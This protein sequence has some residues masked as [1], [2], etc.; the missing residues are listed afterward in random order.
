MNYLKNFSNL[1]N[2]KKSLL[3]CIFSTLLFQFIVTTIVFITIYKFKIFNPYTLN[4][5]ALFVFIIFSIGLIA[6]MTQPN[7]K[8]YQ[9]FILFTIFS[10]TEG[11]F[12]SF[13]L[14]LINVDTIMSALIGTIALFFVMFV[15]GLFGVYYNIDLTWMGLILFL[16]LLGLIFALIVRLFMPY[17]NKMNQG[18]V[19]FALILFS[20]YVIY[21]TNQILLR[22]DNNTN[23]DCIMGSLDYYLDLINIFVNMI[24]IFNK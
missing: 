10:I 6:L 19:I 16:L 17:S 11:V 18:L 12:L 21:D 24:S 8:F 13:C 22:Y 14:K 20:I 1:I 2:K 3:K 7:L 23:R 15:I 9:R 5:F 4:Y